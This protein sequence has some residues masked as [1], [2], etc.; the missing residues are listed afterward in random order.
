MG[1]IKAEKAKKRSDKKA[2]KPL[3]S[4]DLAAKAPKLAGQSVKKKEKQTRKPNNGPMGEAMAAFFSR[5]KAKGFSGPE[6][7]ALWK[8][9][10]TRMAI[11]E[12]LPSPERRRRRFV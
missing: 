8:T 7:R 11:I 12:S 5:K 10:K 2:S 9:S 6:I 4:S 1:E 3:G